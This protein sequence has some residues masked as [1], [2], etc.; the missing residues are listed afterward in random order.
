MAREKLLKREGRFVYR[1]FGERLICFPADVATQKDIEI[2]REIH[3]AFV[4][5][6][7]I[8]LCQSDHERVLRLMRGHVISHESCWQ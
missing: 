6:L 2:M 5:G 1:P 7:E 3:N 4:K 8:E